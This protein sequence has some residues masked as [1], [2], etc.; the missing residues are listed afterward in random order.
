[1][2]ARPETGEFDFEMN[3][4]SFLNTD[5]P[6]GRRRAWLA[7]PVLLLALA[8]SAGGAFDAEQSSPL[9]GKFRSGPA[10]H[11]QNAFRN[12]HEE[13]TESVVSI[14]TRGRQQPAHP[15]FNHPL[16]RYYFGEQ[17]PKART[18]LGSGFIISKD[19][20]I[21][22]NYHVIK[23]MTQ[24]MVRAADR[25]YPARVIGADE[26]TDIALLKIDGSFRPVYFGDS[27]N[28]R[29]GDWAIAIGNPFGLDRTF[30]VGVI[31]AL[32]RNKVD[33]AGGSYIQTDASINPG[34]SGGPLINLD[35]EVIGVNRMIYSRSG[36]SLGI[37]FAIPINQARIVLNRLRETGY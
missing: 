10:G 28:A 27:D 29:V 12:I 15:L 35:G 23:G 1:M 25:V 33:K 7:V 24:I 31:S 19:G 8:C 18:G 21:C 36:G 9:H 26:K 5:F 22:T 37:G 6:G 4:K 32:A 13:Y 2:M 17:Q 30:T 34:N 11:L 14:Y 16:F 3:V 20:Y